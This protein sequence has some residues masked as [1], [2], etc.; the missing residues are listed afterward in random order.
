L[1]GGFLDANVYYVQ[2]AS[3]EQERETGDPRGKYLFFFLNVRGTSSQIRLLLQA[4]FRFGQFA[5]MAFGVVCM[6]M[7][8]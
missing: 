3:R 4:N 7:V 5:A 1:H 2:A 8:A 6:F